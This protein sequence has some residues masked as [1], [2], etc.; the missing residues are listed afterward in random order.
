MYLQLRGS[1]SYSYQLLHTYCNEL[2][3][4][5]PD[6]H[7]EIITTQG[8]RFEAFFWT[9]GIT[10][11]AY[12]NTLR[13]II[14]VDGT[15]LKGRYPG[16]VLTAITIEGNNHVYPIAFAVVM[17]ENNDYWEWFFEKLRDHVVGIDHEF[18]LL[19]DRHKSIIQAVPK[20]LPKACHMYCA[21]HMS[22]KYGNAKVRYL[23][24]EAA[25]CLSQNQ[26]WG[27]MLQIYA[28]SSK[29]YDNL[30]KIGPLNKWASAF[31]EKS[32]YIL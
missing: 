3:L 27:I 19:S 23:L 16:V 20:I 2:K 4:V 31:Q 12:R 28:I 26:F 30:M 22:V 25:K 1:F 29:A 17:K 10:V 14:M 6:A 7:T 32:R 11:R 13:P 18:V 5:D 9:Y 8:D 15:F 24:K 21:Q